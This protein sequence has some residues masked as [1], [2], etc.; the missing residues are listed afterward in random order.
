MSGPLVRPVL[1]VNHSK[2]GLYF[3]F[4]DFM[5]QLYTLSI[6]NNLLFFNANSCSDYLFDYF[7]ILT[8]QKS[9]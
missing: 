4:N 5:I 9:L 3:V 1:F 2:I 8:T 6:K 7:L